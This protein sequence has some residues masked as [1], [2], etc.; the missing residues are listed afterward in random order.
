MTLLSALRNRETNYIT[1]GTVG[2]VN[3]KKLN[4]FIYP[5]V[6]YLEVGEPAFYIR[7]FTPDGKVRPVNPPHFERW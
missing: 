4:R 5:N 2:H 3:V 6:S 1:P 7:Q